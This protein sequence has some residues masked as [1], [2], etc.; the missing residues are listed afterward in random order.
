M[1][2]R[3]LLAAAA[4]PFAIIACSSPSTSSRTAAV[5][6]PVA[7]QQHFVVESPHGDRL[8]EYYW[9]RDDDPQRKRDEVMEYL[10]AEQ[11]YAEAMLERLAPLQATLSQEIRGRIKEDDATVPQHDRGW[12]YWTAFEPG[13][14]QP[15]WMRRKGGVDGPDPDAAPEVLLD[16]NELA[17]GE[18]YFRLGT[19]EVSPDGTRLAWTMD[20][21]GRRGHRLLVKDLRTGELL[22]DRIDGTLESI[23]WANDGR[24]FFYQ[25]QDPVLLQSGPIM[26]HELGTPPS[27]DRVVFDEPDDELFTGFDASRDRKWLLISTGTYDETELKAVPLDDPTKAPMVV[28]PMRKGVRSYADHLAGR[29]VIRTNDAA[30]DFRLVLAS[31]DD[32]ADRSRWRDLVPERSQT[33]LD[34]FVLLDR[35]VAIGERSGANAQVRIV[36]W[37]GGEGWVVPVEAEAFSMWLD[38]NPDPSNESLRVSFTTMTTPRTVLDV[39]LDSR[40]KRLRKVQPVL[41]Y[42]ASK[43]ESARLWAPSRDGQRIPISI[44]WRKDSW[45]RDGLHPIVLEAYGSYGFA[46]DAVF[47]PASVSLMDRGF[48]VATAHVRGGSDLGQGWYEDGR[49]M[50][51]MNSFTDFIDATDFLVRERWADPTRVFATGGSAGGLLMGGLANMAGDRYRGMGVH[52]PFVDALTTMLDA[53][54]PLTTNEWTQWGN[55]IESKEAY[56]YILSYSPYDNLEAKDYPAML[57][58]TGLWDSQVQYFEPAKYVAR[59][60][61]LK[62]D[63]EPL[64]FWIEMEAG[65][66]GRSGRFERIDRVAREQAF[67]IDLAEL[68]DAPR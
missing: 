60:R 65:H 17:R 19:Y 30:P 58:T 49:L 10:D 25:R 3:P 50:H 24:S 34:D 2:S 53:S 46:S 64:V 26:L 41:G 8:D 31:D 54:I 45:S 44:A 43:Y 37:E 39:D 38:D 14:E 57:V 28:L 20:L 40:E 16:G 42:D 11:A 9:L 5:A 22:P 51:K 55:P 61:R 68:A 47:D 15:R 21:Q 4:I 36:P 12:W 1:R 13:D 7:K 59:L 56:E 18:D 52:V 27:R 23:V 67:F 33:S 29:W 32:P 62:T 63:D 48:A 6:P 66:G 35:G